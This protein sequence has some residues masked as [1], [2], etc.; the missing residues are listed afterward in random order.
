MDCI[1]RSFLISAAVQYCSYVNLTVNFRAIS[2][3][4]YTF[5]LFT[6]ML[7]TFMSYTIIRRVIK[8]ETW[9]TVAGMAVGGGL[10]DLTGI[11]ITRH[12]V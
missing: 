9:A 8:D 7:A 4:Q 5:A 1:V 6:A 11:Y 3:E 2:K 12:W 10:G